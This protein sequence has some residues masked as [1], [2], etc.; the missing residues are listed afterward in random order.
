M[1][2]TEVTITCSRETIEIL[3]AEMADLGFDS[4]VETDIG[5]QAYCLSSDYN[6]SDVKLLQKKYCESLPFSF[7]RSIIEKK[8]WNEEWEKNFV[9]I[10][11]GSCRIRASFHQTDP[12]FPFELIIDPKMSF[13]T[14]HHET[15]S[16][17]VATQLTMDFRHHSVLDCGFGTGI[18]SILAIKLGASKVVGTE[19]DD[20]CI[21]NAIDNSELNGIDSIEFRSGTVH[22]MNPSETFDIILANINKNVLLDEIP[23]Y[24]QKLSKKG[25]LLISGFYQSDFSD[26]QALC[27]KH[28]LLPLTVKEKNNWIAASFQISI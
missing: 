25:E 23:L 12:N 5:L 17:M 27:K 19:I 11:I 8:N 20:W 22:D 21:G 15:T 9:P 10:E 1:D 6:E 26:I 28:G 7:T 16:L 13:G 4:M 24:A 14:G 2:F 3:I 18:L